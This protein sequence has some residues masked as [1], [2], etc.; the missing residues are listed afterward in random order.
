MKRNYYISSNG[1]LSRKDNSLSFISEDGSNKY[2]PVEDVD[3][4][5]L[6]GE[7]NINTKLLNFMGQNG[8]TM[9]VFNY[10][11]FYTGSFHP[12][13]SLNSGF[14]YV[15]QVEHY[16]DKN[17][18]IIIAKEFIRTAAYNINRNV[19]YYQRRGKDL[20][21][22]IDYIECL[23]K[24]IENVKSIN[25]LMGIEG[26]IRKAYYKS[27][28]IIINQEV[29]FDK[30]V[31]HPPDNMINA[32]ISFVNMLMYTTVLSEIY[33]TQLVPVVSFLHEPGFRRYSLSLDIAEIFKPLIADR[34]IFSMLNKQQ[35][36]EKDFIIDLNYTYIKDSAR[37]KILKEFDER[38]NTKIKHRKLNKSVSYRYLIRLELYKLV[39]H[40]SGD[41]EY[42][43]FKIWW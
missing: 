17:K 1:R 18:R 32:L 2:I 43:G 4:I 35:I 42:E 31:K 5:Y 14:V 25:E 21:D 12:K 15:K 24:S 39:K 40:I 34:L 23:G 29:D 20:K 36:T 16:L 11:G 41:T 30:R 22:Y 7:L 6:F 19:K 9:H 33:H 13:E 8:I 10:Y 37:K 27:Y 28:N 26:N 3:S 38:L